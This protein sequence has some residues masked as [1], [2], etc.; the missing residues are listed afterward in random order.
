VYKDRCDNVCAQIFTDRFQAAIERKIKNSECSDFSNCIPDNT[1]ILGVCSD[2][3]LGSVL[4][5]SFFVTVASALCLA[6]F[7]AAWY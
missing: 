2:R 7:K 3:S 1:K 4:L 5:P 6:M